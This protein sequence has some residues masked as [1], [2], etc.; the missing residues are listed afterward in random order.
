M[1]AC[2][3]DVG[4]NGEH[5]PAIAGDLARHNV[6]VGTIACRNHHTRTRRRESLRDG[7]ADPFARAGDDGDTVLKLFHCPTI[8]PME[9][10]PVPGIRGRR[11]AIKASN[12]SGP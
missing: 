11:S 4:W 7:L 8:L 10:K 1:S 12:R 2:D 9:T 3:G 5:R 6:E